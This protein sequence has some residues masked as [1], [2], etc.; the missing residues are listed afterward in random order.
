MK[1]SAS[2]SL[3]NQDIAELLAV[4]AE[5]AKPPVQKALRRASRSSASLSAR[6][7]AGTNRARLSFST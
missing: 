1:R 6:L 2:D 7:T 5:S 4:Q 3:R